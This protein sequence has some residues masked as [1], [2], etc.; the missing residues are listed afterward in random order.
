M[1]T[2]Q[3]E[4]LSKVPEVTLYFWIIKI[5]CTT[6]GETASDFLNVNLGLGLKGTS[7]AMGVL[8]LAALF[9]QFKTK[10]Y[11]PAIYWLTVVLISIF[12]TLATDNLTDILGVPLELTTAVFTI[13]LMFTF[14]FWYA[15]EG[16]LSIHSIYTGRREIFYWL[17]ILFTF[18]LG[19]AAGDLMAEGLGLGYVMTGIIVF[20]V[21][22]GATI[23]W[24]LGLD[25]VLAFWIAYILTRPLGASLG[26]YL[27]Q[28]HAN[29]GLELGAPL[30]SAIF[31]IAIVVVV[32]FLTFTK[33]D[34]IANPKAM[35][36]KEKKSPHVVWQTVV[37]VAL[38]AVAAGSGYHW[39]V[40]Q[41]QS[42]ATLDAVATS[43]AAPL[44][45]LSIFRQIAADTLVIVR[46]GDLPASKTRIRDLEFAWDNAAARLK[47]MNKDKWI[48]MDDTIDVV[49]RN[50]RSARLDAATCE[51]SLTTLIS[52]IDKLDNR[53]P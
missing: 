24:R 14:I 16:T 12:G 29:G 8:L 28:S 32:I 38:L 53:K 17:V 15:K 40:G 20:V 50:L 47:P 21:I 34:F 19:T 48:E 49:L 36:N 52:L 41:L 1:K 5:L 23:A 30:T 2:P 33:M 9:F 45:D 7:I 13:A 18:A 27:S 25:A 3:H 42:Q 22:A 44:G 51:T 6:V 31:T 10:R 39:R 35:N 4:M 26:D 11:M 37:V 43:P 46:A